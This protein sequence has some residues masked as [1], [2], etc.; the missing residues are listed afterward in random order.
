[1]QYYFV[2]FQKG[3][4]GEPYIVTQYHE[5]LAGVGLIV[6][7]TRHLDISTIFTTHATL[8]GRYLCAGAV[9]VYNNLDKVLTHVLQSF[10]EKCLKEMSS[11]YLTFIIASFNL[12][13]N[14]STLVQFLINY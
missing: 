1:M 9:D 2:Q 5:W 13:S 7:R 4:S 10:Q 12:F 6:S 8:L 3:L 11:T 14:G